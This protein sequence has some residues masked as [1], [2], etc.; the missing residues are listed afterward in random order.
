MLKL[1]WA[2]L[3]CLVVDEG[4][5]VQQLDLPERALKDDASLAQAIPDLAKQAISIYQELQVK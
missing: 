4:V 2:V 3:L 5:S 1:L